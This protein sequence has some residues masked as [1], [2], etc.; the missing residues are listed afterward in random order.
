ME[1]YFE[2]IFNSVNDGIFIHT[3]EGRFLEVNRIMCDDLGYQKDELLQMSVMD[4]TPPEFRE[5]T[6]K[7]VVEKLKQGGGIFETVSK[8][9]DGSLAKV[10]LNVRPIDY[11]GTPAILTVARNVTERKEMEK[12]LRKSEIS[13]ANAQR[14]AHLGN[15]DWDI[16]TNELYWSDEI[17]R[18]FGL[19]PNEFGATYDAFL[20]S[21]HPDDRIFVQDA[22]DKAVYENDPYNIDHRIL[23]PDGSERIVHEQGEVTF[24]ENGQGL[25]MVGTVQ[26]ITERK[27]IE[28]EVII[29]EKAIDSSL[30]AIVF[31]DLKGK[32]LFANPSFLELWGY[33]NKN[34]IIGLNGNKLWNYEIDP[35]EIQN[36]LVSTGSWKGEAIARKK[37]GREF[38]VSTS[39]HFIIDDIGNPI[40]LMASF[41]DITERK[42]KDKLLIE[43]AKAEAS[44]RAKSELLS[45][46]SHE[47]RTPLTIIIGYSDLLDMQ[48]IGTLNQKQ[49]SCVENV[50][51]SSH[52][53][54]S[55]INDTLDLSKAEAHK[56]ELNIEEFFIP[57]VIDDVKTALMPLTSSKNLDLLT[58]V[59]S[60]IDTIKADKKKFKQILYN[61]MSNALKF[62]PEKGSITIETHTANNMVQ[63]NVIDNGIGMSEENM[64][65]IFQPFQQVNTPETKEQQGTGLGLALTKKFVKMHGG[66]VWVKSE[67]GKGTTFSFTLPFD[68]EIQV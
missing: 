38:S 15:W 53:L 66:K 37:D 59:N 34:E 1:H 31:A 22:V 12:A 46:M 30:N 33:D 9:K 64:K 20:N 41:V 56:M 29:K 28:K 62:T 50:L 10:E 24:N 51:E 3:P 48:E 57:D 19:A 18:I 7:Q 25:R 42:I 16:V 47:M 55:L 58:N 27:K 6:G 68:Q 36:S 14:I 26:D 44:S 54:L 32:I 61:L 39:S 63:F 8:C 67:L 5:A 4:I 45:T 60:D 40:C 52:H 23:L 13:L 21:V 65:R 43:K 17:Y 35:L 11:K 49:A 2:M